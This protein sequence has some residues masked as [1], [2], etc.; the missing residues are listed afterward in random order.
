MQ[1]TFGALLAAGY[2]ASFAA[3]IAAARRTHQNGVRHSVEAQL[4]SRSPGA[5]AVAQQ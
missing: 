2:A 5:E 1:S 4:T 3:A